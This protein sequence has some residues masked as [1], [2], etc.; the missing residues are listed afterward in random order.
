MAGRPTVVLLAV[1]AAACGGGSSPTTPSVPP[2]SPSPTPTP[3]ASATVLR[4]A[5]FQSANGY[6]T[7]GQAAIV[8]EGT[9]H[10]LELRDDFRTSQSAA[11]DVRLCRE[12]RCTSSDLNLGEVRAFSGSQQ[13]ALPDDGAAYRYAVIWCRA[14]N[15]PFGFGELR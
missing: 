13:Y 1:L 7:E 2:P 5:V 3:D 4:S 8:R 11:L 12:T 10:R 9:A 15:L 14:V 6:T